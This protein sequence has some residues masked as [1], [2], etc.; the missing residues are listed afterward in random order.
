MK[1]T[2]S[3]LMASL[4]LVTITIACKNKALHKAE[5]P[6]LGDIKLPAGF[7]ISLYA[8]SIVDARLSSTLGS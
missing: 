2:A 1:H 7:H 6:R 8:D 3:M 5:D 4:A